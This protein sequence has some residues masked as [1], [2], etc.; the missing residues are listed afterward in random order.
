M[1][2]ELKW[3]VPSPS[4][5][6][7]AH[8]SSSEFLHFFPLSPRKLNFEVG[9]VQIAIKEGRSDDLPPLIWREF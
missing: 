2:S 4:C 1:L 7:L 9:M 3:A 8:T 5:N 6:R